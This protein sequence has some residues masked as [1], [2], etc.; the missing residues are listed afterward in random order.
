MLVPAIMQQCADAGVKSVII[1][2]AGFREVGKEGRQLEDQVIQIARQAGIRV[3]GPN[4][5][6]V[7]VPANN[8]NASFGGDLPA[9]GA[10][11]YLSQSGALLA[12]ILDMAVQIASALANWLA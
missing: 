1:I 9:A 2:T 12:A 8:L 4:C 3:I 5:L 11:G 7:I 10:I 6:G